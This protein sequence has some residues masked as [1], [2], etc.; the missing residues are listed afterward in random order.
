M[1]AVC[2][3]KGRT[4]TGCTIC[5]SFCTEAQPGVADAHG[6][7]ITASCDGTGTT[8]VQT[9]ANCRLCPADHYPTSLCDGRSFT[10][11]VECK[12]CRTSC[13]AGYYLQGNCKVEEVKCVPCDMPCTNQSMFL[14]E[15]RA[16]TNGQNRICTV[17]GES[18]MLWDVTKAIMTD[19]PNILSTHFT[20]TS[21][22]VRGESC[23]P[24]DVTKAIMTDVSTHF[25]T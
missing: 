9:C 4:D 10:D 20:R 8:D 14:Q 17:Q 18:C 1:S 12:P 11:T 15:T 24:W 6:Q 22:K 21:H 13:P 2:S 25:T 3:G 5:R 16:C 7:F 23:M 19:L